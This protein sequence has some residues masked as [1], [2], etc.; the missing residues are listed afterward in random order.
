MLYAAHL[1]FF[2]PPSPH[3]ESER[4]AH[5]AAMGN[6]G[7]SIP[8]RRELV[9][10]VARDPSATAL[11]KSQQEQQNYQWTTDPV[12]QQPLERPVVSDAAGRLYNK[13]TILEFLVDGTRA[14]EFEAATKGSVKSLKDVVE[15]VFEMDDAAGK[16]EQG[17][18]WKC[19]VTGD[20]LGP[21]A[22]A[23]YVVPCGH[24]FGGSAVKEASSLKTGKQRCLTCDAEYAPNDLIPI[25]P[26][27]PTDITRLALRIKTLQEMGLSHSLKKASTSKKRKKKT[28]TEEDTQAVK[29]KSTTN[30]INNA[31]TASLTS[32]VLQEQEQ[33]KRRRMD[34]ETVKSLFSSRDQ[35]KPIG[36]S[37]DFMT[38]GFSLPT[39]N[40]R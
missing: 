1:T 15:I 26:T 37:A 33:A 32:K 18:K 2:Q 23:V 14:A 40:K 13:S 5:F 31:A 38:R 3:C 29:N 19:P 12:S 6:D 22:K 4:R 10:E 17:E 9:K 25:I 21:A 36:K 28:E 34:N 27:A 20:R 35:T 24:A 7:G 8:T 30:G 39:E 11:K 16:D